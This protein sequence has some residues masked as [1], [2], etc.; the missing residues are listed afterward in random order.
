MPEN[1]GIGLF[2]LG[3]VLILIALVGGKFKIFVA[4][5][6][7]AVTSP[8]I[9]IIAFALGVMFILLSL[10]PTMISAALAAVTDTPPPVATESPQS[11]PQPTQTSVQPIQISP[12]PTQTS[13]PP[14]VI[15]DTPT[16]PGLSPAEFVI[17]YW[18]NVSDGRYENAWAQ[19]SPGFRQAKHNNDYSAYVYGYQQMNLCRIVVSSVNVVQQDFYSAV[20]TAHFTYY[21]GAQCNSSEYDFEMWLAYDGASNSWLFDKNIINE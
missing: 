9:R 15:Y 12:E 18:Q 8:F 5:V 1:L 2:V 17:S 3:A 20:V 7:P 6:S 19:L 4:E 14:T 16:P 10:N 11:I 13:L 21:T